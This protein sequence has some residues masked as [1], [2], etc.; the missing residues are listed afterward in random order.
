MNCSSDSDASGELGMSGDDKLVLASNASSDGRGDDVPLC[1][2]PAM[3]D[4]FDRSAVDGGTC[5]GK[6]ML[7]S[8]QSSFTGERLPFRCIVCGIFVGVGDLIGFESGLVRGDGR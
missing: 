6:V 3:K 7:S 5:C 4:V 8:V 1:A 2:L